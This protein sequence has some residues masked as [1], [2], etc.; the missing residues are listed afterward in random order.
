MTLDQ[1]DQDILAA[2]IAARATIDGARVG[3]YVK[4]PDG[5]IRQLTYDWGDSL[6]T[7]LPNSDASFYL[8]GSGH[9]DFSGSLDSAIPRANLHLLGMMNA[10]VWFFHHDQARAHNGVNATA[11]CR[12]FQY[13][14]TP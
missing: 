8:T 2:R 13:R 5:S 12:V 11:P 14:V 6:Q 1:R 10:R 7:T 9:L 4:M 3:D